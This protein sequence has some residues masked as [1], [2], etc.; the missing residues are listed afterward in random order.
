[1][2]TDEFYINECTVHQIVIQNLNMIKMCAKM[3]PKKLKGDQRARRNEVSA[4]ILEQ[5]ETQRDFLNRV[6]TSDES[7]FV[8][9]YDLRLRG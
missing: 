4:G 1:M 2:T 8:F 5:L 6:M 7:L 9:E 3:V